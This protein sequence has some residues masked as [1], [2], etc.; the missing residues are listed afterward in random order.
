MD[1]TL[2]FESNHSKVLYFEKTM[3]HCYNFFVSFIDLV[4]E[5]KNSA[6][7]VKHGSRLKR[8]PSLDYM[9]NVGKLKGGI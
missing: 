1:Q 4:G 3:S 6:I 8:I 2:K 5:L 7:E 9:V